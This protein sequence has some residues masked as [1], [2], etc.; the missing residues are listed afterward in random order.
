MHVDE[1]NILGPFEPI[2]THHFEQSNIRWIFCKRHNHM[3]TKPTRSHASTHSHT[4]TNTR[5][6]TYTFQVIQ[7][8]IAF[9]LKTC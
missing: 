6:H 4:C 2:R 3:H 5:T 8:N 7:I 1:V 9:E